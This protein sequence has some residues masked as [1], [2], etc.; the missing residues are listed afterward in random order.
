MTQNNNSW[1]RNYFTLLI[2]QGVSFI[3]SGILQMAIIF[4]LVAK[5]NSAII[6]T[7]ATLIGFL[8]Q[9]CLGPFA[10]VFVDRHSRKG[11]MIGADLMIA[12]AGGL[13]ALAAL[14]TELPVWAIMVVLF[15]RSTGTAFH[16]PAFSATTPM[17]VP[18]DELT[19]CAGYAQTIQAVSS[20]ISPAAAAFLY[21]VWPLNAIIMLD[22]VGAIL[23]CVTVA[24]SAIPTPD[25]CTEQKSQQ[26]M[27]DIKEG[28]MVLKRNRGLFALLWI[29][30]IYMFFYMPISSLYPLISMSYFGGTPAHA[31][32][33]EI[34]FAVGMLLGG[35]ILSI[36]GGFKRRTHTI[37]FSILLMGI[38]ITV[39][40]LLPSGAFLI[41]IV[42]CTAMG[43]AAPFY[44]V[45]NAIFQET[46]KPEY[47]GRV[48]SLLT[49]AASFAMPLGLLIS[50]PLAEK[51]GVEK[52]FVI[53]GV[54]IIIVALTAFL[55]PS[56]R[57][58][59]D[60]K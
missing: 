15:I 27:Q 18:K 24:I 11:V 29:G 57:K 35:I 25:V 13:L 20:I 58:I 34:A 14:Y 22:I 17:I 32:A 5:T 33:A 1:K 47:L 40:G 44:G 30:V 4:Y 56:L 19:K 23:A 36:W 59:D 31:S 28:Y 52:W 53:C 51:F 41:F 54:G 50:G 38:S 16:S 6:L 48:F 8:P 26:F 37:C 9:A 46:I 39:S 10:G 3:S 43:I 45:Q 21:A 60:T 12:A 7:I 49:S 2:G 55:L 42:C